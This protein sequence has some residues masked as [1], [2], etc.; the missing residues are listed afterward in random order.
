MF[1]IDGDCDDQSDDETWDNQ[2]ALDRNNRVFGGVKEQKL[3]VADEVDYDLSISIDDIPHS[4]SCFSYWISDR[5][6][7]I[8]DL[9]GILNTSRSPP[10]YEL[11]DPVIHHR[12]SHGSQSKYGRTDKGMEGIHAF[13]ATHK[14]S[15]LCRW[16]KKRRLLRMTNVVKLETSA[17]H[18]YW[19]PK[20]QSF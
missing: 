1:T 16:P 6:Y 19:L 13:F 11:T 10:V 18:G 4:F 15:N 3:L 20:E 9:Q 14:C 8:C 5:K 7:L 2:G 17:T 12:S